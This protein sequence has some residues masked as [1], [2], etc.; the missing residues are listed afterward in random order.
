MNYYFIT[1]TSRGIGEAMTLQLLK[2]GNNFVYGMS[3]SSSVKHKNYEHI[4]FD[5]NDVDL[6]SAFQFPDLN[7]VESVCFINNSAYFAEIDYYPNVEQSAVIENYYVNSISPALLI[8][9][10]LKQFQN[11]SFRRMIINISSGAARRPVESWALYCSSKASAEMLCQVLNEEQKIKYSDNPVKIFSIAPGVVDT[12]AQTDIRKTDP[13]KFSQV[14]R[15]INYKN[16]N[17]LYSPE[18]AAERILRVVNYPDKFSDVN[19][20]IRTFDDK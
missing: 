3:R 5:L 20:D 2:D 6:V 13:D 11:A 17:D 14:G 16:N 4:K 9:T 1:G 15:F 8:N 19:L 7:E 18:E 10:F 12:Q